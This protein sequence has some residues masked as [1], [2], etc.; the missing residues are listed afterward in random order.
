MDK[1]TVAILLSTYN[2]QDHVEEQLDTLLDQTYSDFTVFIRD[3]GS[4][5][6]TREIVNQWALKSEK[7]RILKDDFGN[8]G[9][10]ESYRILMRSV[11]SDYYFFA[12]QDDIWNPIK[13]EVLMQLA[14]SSTLKDTPYL[15]FSNMEVFNDK[16][17]TSY[18]FFKRFRLSEE[19]V[20]NGLFQGTIS[21]CLMLF[22]HKAK[23]I[24]L[25]L[26]TKSTM[27]HD[28]DVL[29]TCYVY[30][31]I[32][33]C[34]Q[35]LIKHRIHG[36][37]AIGDSH[38]QSTLV[39]LKDFLKYV[40][41]SGQYRSIH[42]NDYFNYIENCLLSIPTELRLQRQLFT[43]TEIDQLSYFRR[44]KWYLKHFNPFIY[45]KLNGLLILMTV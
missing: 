15:A 31:T 38:S 2:G 44:K 42:L 33:V 12:D 6:R 9:V 3:D 26:N 16:K 18:D 37:N 8:V 22:N 35:Q 10:A 24:S 21:G 29:F 28:W 7:I 5:D 20:K 17:N 39:R 34:H 13:L 45:G 36:A 1:P 32:D 4:S 23:E 41:K 25:E 30:G 27:L 19:K 40:F 11:V 14:E 43:A